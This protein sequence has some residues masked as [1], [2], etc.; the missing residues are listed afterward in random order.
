[1]VRTPGWSTSSGYL[2]QPLNPSALNP[3]PPLPQPLTLNPKPQSQQV[4]GFNDITEQVD[5]FDVDDAKQRT[6]HLERAH[7]VLLPRANANGKECLGKWYP[8]GARV[9]AM[10][11]ETT[12]FYPAIVVDNTLRRNGEPYCSLHFDDDEDI[13]GTLPAREVPVRFIT[14]LPPELAS[15]A[16]AAGSGEVAEGRQW[17][18]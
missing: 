11:P 5:V 2:V 18:G 3:N 10:Y 8:K 15:G 1:M 9:F 13:M 14:M 7:V 4:V 17:P 6:Y 16:Q 12:G